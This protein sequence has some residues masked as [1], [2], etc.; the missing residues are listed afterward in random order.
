M[1]V[2]DYPE[3]SVDIDTPSKD[4]FV[5]RAFTHQC[6]ILDFLKDLDKT[7]KGNMDKV[8]SKITAEII[9]L[10]HVITDQSKKITALQTELDCQKNS[11]K[12][13]AEITKINTVVKQDRKKSRSRSRSKIKISHAVIVKPKNE[14]SSDTT[15]SVLQSNINPKEINVR[16]EGIRKISNGGIVIRTNT[17]A[18]AAVMS[19]KLTS[20]T[21]INSNYAITLP[22]KRKPQIIL[23]EVSKD[24]NSSELKNLIVEHNDFI[25]PEDLDIKKN[26]ISRSGNNNWI[27]DIEPNVYQQLDDNKITIGWQR[28]QF[29]EYIRPTRC[30]KCGRLGH[31]ASNCRNKS[32][33]IR[34]GS[35][36]HLS[37]D[38]NAKTPNCINCSEHNTRY[39]TKF[40]TNHSCN[41]TKCK[42]WVKEKDNIIARTNYG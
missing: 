25:K 36:E 41:D 12:T 37:K 42:C 9:E 38:C 18:E 20:T 3:S 6:K 17:A 2:I 31:I 13:Y 14:Q 19:D 35:T 34:C 16:I 23:Y 8:K 27:V 11:T 30:Y 10:M 29:R 7:T 32:S 5:S 24:I 21:S 40:A 33:C 15:L 28:I 1:S 22:K 4:D 26:Y 39:K